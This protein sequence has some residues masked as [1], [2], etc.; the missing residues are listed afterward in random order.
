VV[1]GI[2]AEAFEPTPGRQ[3]GRCDFRSICPEF[4][5]VPGPEATRLAELVDRLEQLRGDEHRV[6]R[7]LASTADELHRAAEQ[8]G[9]HRI[10]GTRAVAI[11]RREES[12]QYTLD[13]VRPLLERSGVADRLGGGT[14]DEVRKL[15]R[16]PEIP[17]ELRRKVAETGS[18]QIRWYWELEEVDAGVRR[19]R[20][21][22]PGPTDTA[23]G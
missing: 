21:P 9:V 8:L 11:R 7:D 19:V 17:P 22:P 4:R 18:R 2:R 23:A 13:P 1:D 10:P 20:P 16:D 5:E 12:W 6:E 3:C 14:P 15:L